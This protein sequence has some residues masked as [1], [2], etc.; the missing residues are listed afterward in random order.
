MHI[1]TAAHIAICFIGSR[2]CLLNAEVVACSKQEAKGYLASQDR[3]EKELQASI[4]VNDAEKCSPACNSLC[5]EFLHLVAGHDGS[6]HAVRR[7]QQHQGG[8]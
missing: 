5:S 6:L 2:K 4:Q 7:F 1:G 8:I 3:M